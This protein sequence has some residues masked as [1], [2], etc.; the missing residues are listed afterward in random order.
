MQNLSL[1]PS[2]TIFTILSSICWVVGIILILVA[3]FSLGY[4]IGGSKD[5]IGNTSKFF[6]MA[7]EVIVVIMILVGTILVTTGY[8]LGK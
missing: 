2:E 1:E 6:L 4:G 7:I 3:L 5:S 8:Y